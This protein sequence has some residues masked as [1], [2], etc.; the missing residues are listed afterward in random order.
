MLRAIRAAETALAR[1]KWR[2]VGTLSL[3]VHQHIVALLGSQ[4]LDEFFRTL[5]A[6][7]RLVFASEPDESRIQTADWIER[8]YQIY[9]FLAADRCQ[10]ASRAL[11]AYLD[12]SE[13]TLTDVLIRSKNAQAE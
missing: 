3:Q 9:Q 2:D 4:L 11:A 8:E 5:C 10:E 13:H 7:L 12:D 6:Q 1:G